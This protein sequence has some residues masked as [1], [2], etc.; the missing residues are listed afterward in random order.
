MGEREDKVERRRERG[1]KK[2]GR[3]TKRDEGG[4]KDIR[5]EMERTGNRREYDKTIFV[6][7]TGRKR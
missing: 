3:G 7:Q 4:K 5:K 1:N 6:R 2:R